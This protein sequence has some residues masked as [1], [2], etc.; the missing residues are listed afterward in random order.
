[1]PASQ[2]SL[3]LL[4]FILS[5]GNASAST[6]S[7][8]N[9][10]TNLTISF[11][12]NSTTNFLTTILPTTTLSP[13]TTPLLSTSRHILIL[14]IKFSSLT[15]FTDV[16]ITTSLPQVHDILKSLGLMASFTLKLLKTHDV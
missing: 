4:L 10:T 8:P 1:M 9:P 15:P 7:S 12:T 5:V 14:S 3:M 2:S 6:N 16:N 11:P 13:T